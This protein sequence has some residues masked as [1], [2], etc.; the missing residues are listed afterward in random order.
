MAAY[1]HVACPS[2][3]TPLRAGDMSLD[4]MAGRCPAC[5]ALVDLRAVAPDLAAA[6]EPGGDPIPVPLPARVHVE[7]RGRD[8]TIT[9]RWFSWGYVFLLFFC[10]MWDGFLV[11]W[12]GVALTMDAPLPFIL[13]PLL[14]VAV[15]VFLTYMT[16]AGFVNR[17]TFTIERDR[18]IVRHGPL[19]WRGSV[20]VSTISVEQLFCTEKISRG[21]NGTTVRYN[22]E[23]VLKDG[24]HLKVATGLDE[25]E[26]ALFIEQTLEKHLGIQNR[27]V[28]SEMAY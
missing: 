26:Q 5:H 2:C 17:T 6:P 21:R 28:R 13:F 7:E 15:G 24:R 19:P 14:H 3:G 18:L 12:Y 25:R 4:T 11:F 9:R 8:L 20:D 10:V 23:A 1:T 16:I 22:V 27:R